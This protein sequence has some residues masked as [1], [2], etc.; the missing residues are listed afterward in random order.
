MRVLIVPVLLMLLV[1]VAIS[2]SID[3]RVR[4]H[5]SNNDKYDDVDLE[6]DKVIIDV[7]TGNK[8][9]ESETFIGHGQLKIN[10]DETKVNCNLKVWLDGEEKKHHV[11]FST[12][13]FFDLPQGNYFM[14]VLDGRVMI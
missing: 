9:E 11:T 5:H 10:E 2:V 14:V 12:F 8:L 3:Y 13:N 4:N 1:M 6:K 7:K